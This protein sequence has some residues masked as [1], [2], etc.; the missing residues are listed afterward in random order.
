MYQAR[1]T[2]KLKF[3]KTQGRCGVIIAEPPSGE[4]FPKSPG[5]HGSI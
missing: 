1:K 4:D 3:V 5:L 2:K